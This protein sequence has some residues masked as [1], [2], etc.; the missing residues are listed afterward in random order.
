MRKLTKRNPVARLLA[1]S[2]YRKQTVRN[3]KVYSRKGN[4]G[5]TKG[6]LDSFETS[7]KTSF[8]II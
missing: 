5:A 2:R 8:D 7:F 1:D 6:S 4:K 3:K